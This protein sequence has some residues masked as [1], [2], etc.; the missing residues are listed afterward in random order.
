M[1]KHFEHTMLIPM[2]MMAKIQHAWAA[3]FANDG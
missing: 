1:R 3:A 2:A